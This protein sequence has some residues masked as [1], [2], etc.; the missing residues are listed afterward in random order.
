MDRPGGVWYKRNRT[1][2]VDMG[3]RLKRVTVLRH[4]VSFDEHVFAGNGEWPFAE[5]TIS[6][7]EGSNAALYA[8][9]N[10]HRFEPIGRLSAVTG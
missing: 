6:G 5:L 2:V 7:F 3:T 4:G 1:F 9:R 8:V 10:R